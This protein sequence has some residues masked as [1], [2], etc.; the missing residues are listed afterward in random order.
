M[1]RAV[2]FD[3]DDTLYPYARYRRSG[4]A[5]VAHDLEART[6]RPADVLFGMLCRASASGPRGMEFQ[7]LCRVCDIPCDEVPL[8]LEAYRRHAPVV[9]PSWDVVPTLRRLRTAGWKLAIVT[10]GTPSVQR[11]KVDALGLGALV[12]AVVCA[13]EHAPDGKPARACFDEALHR[14]GA[15]AEASVHVGDDP[16]CDIAGA[17]GA[18]LR[19]IQ[20]VRPGSPGR[21]DADAVVSRIGE[22]V[23]VVLSMA[24]EGHAHAV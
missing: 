23:D 24:A 16:V 18:G 13:H 3:L 4:F 21:T 17:R 20:I 5:A 7:T 12:D 6:G 15:D 11:M 1:T 2:L 22:V 10:N 14:L 9:W 19:A 8:M